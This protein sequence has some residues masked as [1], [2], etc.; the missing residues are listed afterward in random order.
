METAS[1]NSEK[2]K[3]IGKNTPN[4]WTKNERQKSFVA[5]RTQITPFF[6]FTYSIFIL[7]L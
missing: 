1:E 5:G 6:I 7:Q 4:I 2:R 3:K